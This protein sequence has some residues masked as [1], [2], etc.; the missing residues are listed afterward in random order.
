MTEVDAIAPL[1]V[2]H[3]LTWM[4]SAREDLLF[5]GHF[6]A[7]LAVDP[8]TSQLV[9][10][11]VDGAMSQRNASGDAIQRFQDF[12]LG[13]AKAVREAVNSGVHSFAKALAV[14]GISVGVSELDC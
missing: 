13:D 5:A 10:G 9:A 12:A 3:L 1:T 8:M 14:L 6:N 4:A 2:A 11:L 7:E